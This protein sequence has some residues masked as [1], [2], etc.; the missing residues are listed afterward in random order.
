VVRDVLVVGHVDDPLRDQFAALVGADLPAAAAE[1]AQ[2]PQSPSACAAEV[3]AVLA[4]HQIG[5][6]VDG[7]E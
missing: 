6:P 3:L 5:A 4:A 2:E 7:Q 1:A